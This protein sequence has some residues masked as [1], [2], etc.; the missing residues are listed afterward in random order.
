MIKKPNMIERIIKGFS[1]K[2]NDL[3]DIKLLINYGMKN[4]LI[5][6]IN[7][8]KNEY[9]HKFRKLFRGSHINPLLCK[10]E[11]L[12]GEIDLDKKNYI[13]AYGIVLRAFYILISLKFNRTSGNQKD[14]CNEQKKIDKYLTLIGKYKDKMKN[15]ERIKTDLNLKDNNKK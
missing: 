14:F 1:K 8:P 7:K 10:I 4:G 13:S 9:M 11:L 5:T 3:E 15:I 12:M 6:E 2:K